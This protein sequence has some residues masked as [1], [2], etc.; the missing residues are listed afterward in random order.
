M[1]I[2]VVKASIKPDQHSDYD[3]GFHVELNRDHYYEGE[4]LRKAFD[5]GI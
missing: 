5:P 1:I 4:P 3:I 2:Q